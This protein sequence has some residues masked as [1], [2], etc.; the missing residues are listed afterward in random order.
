MFCPLC[1]AE[2]R[3]GFV[4]CSDCHIALTPSFPDAQHSAVMLWDGYMQRKPDLVLTALA[5]QNVPTHFKET[6]RMRPNPWRLL[7]LRLPFELRSHYEVWVLREDLEKAH[8]A[9][10]PLGFSS[11]S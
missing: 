4:Q 8:S 5:D 7:L 3:E 10:A 2:Y 1:Q 11:G 9:L 6:K